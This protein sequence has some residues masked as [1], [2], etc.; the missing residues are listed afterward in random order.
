MSDLSCVIHM[1][2]PLTLSLRV[3]ILLT[4]NIR[5]SLRNVESS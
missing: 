4:G 3:K 2:V 5:L 1:R